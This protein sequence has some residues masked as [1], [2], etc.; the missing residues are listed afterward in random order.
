[1]SNTTALYRAIAAYM[2]TRS[3]AREEWQLMVR[4][5]ASAKGSQ[6]YV[7]EMK[8]AR[9][10][11][12]KTVADAQFIA[13]QEIREIIKAMAE[14]ADKIKM[15]PPTE[16]QIRILQ[17]LSMKEKV[18]PAELEGAANA[19]NGNTTCLSLVDELARKSGVI[20]TPFTSRL[21]VKS[22]DPQTARQT[23]KNLNDACQT[24]I[25]NISGASRARLLAAEAH[26]RMYGGTFDPYEFPEEAGFADETDFYEK[27]GVPLSAF[28]AAV[29]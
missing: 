15:V 11:M 3:E 7:D 26:H 23:I 24:I 6:M 20:T 18:T 25:N 8:K 29:D 21:S 5:Y 19:M 9:E 22:Y 13:R 27:M 17:L 16:E 4:R 12:D 1:M 10:K 2:L 28:S 14:N